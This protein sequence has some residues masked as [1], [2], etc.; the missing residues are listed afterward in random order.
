MELSEEKIKGISS[1]FVEDQLE[2]E[3]LH[4][5]IPVTSIDIEIEC[6]KQIELEAIVVYLYGKYESSL[7]KATYSSETLYWSLY[8]KLEGTG[9]SREARVRSDERFIE[10]ERCK[11]EAKQRFSVIKVLHSAIG[12]R[13]SMIEQMSNNYRLHKRIDEVDHL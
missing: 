4:K 13:R 3:Y 1:L 6:K 12:S 2:V 7:L 5:S 8:N 10:E 11:V 9:V